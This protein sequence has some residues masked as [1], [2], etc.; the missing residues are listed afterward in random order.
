MDN[1]KKYTNEYRVLSTCSGYGGIELGL[2]IAGVEYRTVTYV[3]I[4]AFAIANL[5]A[6]ME[7]G[8]LYPAPI[9]TNLK[10]F[11][12]NPFCG[13]VDLI[14]GG[15]P[16][17][18]FSAAGKRKGEEDPRHLWP[19]IRSIVETIKPF[20]CFFENVEGHVSL[21]YGQV[22]RDLRDLGYKVEAGIFSSQ[23][24]GGSH[25]RKRL[26]I[27]AENMG[28]S[29]CYNERLRTETRQPIGIN[30]TSER[31]QQGRQQMEYPKSGRSGRWSDETSEEQG[32]G[33]DRSG[34]ELGHTSNDNRG[35]QTISN[36]L[37]N[38]NGKEWENSKSKE[39]NQCS[40]IPIA[41]PSPHQYE[42]EESRQITKDGF[43]SRLGLSVDGYDYRTDILRS[44][45][46]GVDPWTAAKA[47]I[48]LDK[49]F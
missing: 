38:E 20:R 6:K 36:P 3:E 2:D 31:I 41:P 21:G 14:T 1:T 4:E 13:R 42:W 25:Q 18:P 27:M 45:G 37:C 24:T 33:A 12:A 35:G 7:A 46:N 10:T 30:E 9:W 26:F 28:D 11:D 43:K 16:C 34:S 8:A 22:Y 5:V 48:T 29:Q 32:F 23:E 49:L 17:Q 47:W 19:H 40:R 44:Q 39:F 15:Y